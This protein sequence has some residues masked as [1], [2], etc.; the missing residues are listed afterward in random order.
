VKTLLSGA[1]LRV[2]TTG[3]IAGI[4]CALSL[5]QLILGDV[6]AWTTLALAAPIFLIILKVFNEK[7]AG[8]VSPAFQTI[9]S[10]RFAS[11]ITTGILLVFGVA[12]FLLSPVVDQSVWVPPTPT[13]SAL[14]TDWITIADFLSHMQSYTLSQIFSQD[15]WQWLMALLLGPGANAALG[16][17]LAATAALP[18]IEFR[19]VL[20]AATLEAEPKAPS[21]STIGWAS[22]ISTVLCMFLVLPTL[23]SLETRMRAL[24]EERRAVEILNTAAEQVRILVESINGKSVAP[25]TIDKVQE[26][27]RGVLDRSAQAS[28][29]AIR[30]EIIIAADGMIANVDA[31]LDSYYS[32]VGE[33]RRIAL[34]LSGDLAQ[35]LEADLVNALAAGNPTEGL[36]KSLRSVNLDPNFTT[37]REEIQRISGEI[38][39]QNRIEPHPNA[40]LVV[41]EQCDAAP[42]LDL[43]T[44]YSEMNE[45]TEDR[46]L[47]SGLVGAGGS[48]IA[49]LIVK[50]IVAKGTIKVAAKALAK[51]VASKTAASGGGATVGALIGGTLGSV[52]PGAGTAAGAA[53]GGILGGLAVGVSV[54]ALLLE[55]EEALRRDKFKSDIVGAIEIWRSRTLA[56]LE[57]N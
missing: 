20:G 53:I 51:T 43:L 19:R 35:N 26:A 2:I 50:K 49:G 1:A 5:P 57:G 11:R 48:V 42:C 15:I 14:V 37:L 23:G 34:M 38:V 30:K 13:P 41:S 46:L 44:T 8:H 9:Q 6:L 32:L 39:E 18:S 25:G 56:L 47:K 10:L 12:I 17:T 55:L 21:L 7:L 33:Y 22:G 27:A 16:S 36:D 54:D 29:E 4:I 45:D 52:V 24:P 3:A 28:R 40:V 31:Y